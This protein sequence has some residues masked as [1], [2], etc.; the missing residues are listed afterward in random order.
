MPG[1]IA[2]VNAG[3]VARIERCQRAR[4][5]PVIKMTPKMLEFIQRI[6]CLAG[7]FQHLTLRNVAEIPRGDIRQQRQTNVGWRGTVRN[8]RLRNFLE[9]VGR[10]PVFLSVDE[11]FE[12]VPGFTCGLTEETLLLRINAR[13]LPDSRPAHP[14]HHQRRDKPQQ[15]QRQ[16]KPQ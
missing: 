7:T 14:A 11:R 6:E 13:F 15:T 10:Q 5:V 8:H 1:Q 4:V 2:A 3:N 9:I 12:K 16:G